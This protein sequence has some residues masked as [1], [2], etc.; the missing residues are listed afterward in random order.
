MRRPLLAALLL[1]ACQPVADAP[2]GEAGPAP[3]P[4]GPPAAAA[5]TDAGEPSFIDSAIDAIEQAD[6]PII[7]AGNGALRKRAAKQLRRFAYKTGIPVVNTFMGKGAV[8]MSGDHCLFT[9]G[10]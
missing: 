3:T 9:M 7:L 10:L 6:S 4:A 5:A 8:A 1:T 2:F